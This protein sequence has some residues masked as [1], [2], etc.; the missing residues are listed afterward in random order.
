[1]KLYAFDAVDERL[2][3]VP[4]AARRALDHAGVKLSLE[5]WRS[6][7]LDARRRITL[8]GSEADVDRE[9]VQR[10]VATARPKAESMT[11]IADPLSDAPA[12]EV[13]E[14]FGAERPLDPAVWSALSRLDRY[15]LVKV[16]RGRQRER[17]EPAYREIVGHSAYSTHVGPG[18]EARMVSVSEKAVSLRRAHA[19]SRVSMNSEAFMRVLAADA[20]KGDVLGTARLAG[21]MAAKRTSDIIPLCH[22]LALTKIELMLTPDEASSSVMIQ[23]LV[24]AFDRTGVEMEALTAVSAAALTVYDML[25][26]FDRGMQIGP[27]ELVQK[28]GGRSG[29]FHK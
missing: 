25:K 17:I 2:D 14:A 6:L 13:S 8:A 4:L 15:A 9:A 26:A 11:P 20:P 29:D 18:G 7:D 23:A 19:Q 24:E 27:T 22:P 3:L 10:A 21:I 16:A 28:S 1:V 5:G 12:L